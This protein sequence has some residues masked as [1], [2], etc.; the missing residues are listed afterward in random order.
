MTGLSDAQATR[1][2]AIA[3]GQEALAGGAV[4]LLGLAGLKAHYKDNW[5]SVREEVFR[6]AQI[7]VESALSGDDIVVRVGEHGFLLIFADADPARAEDKATAASD[8]AGTTRR[9]RP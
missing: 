8:A 7:A 5:E 6:H 2:K 1:L 9:C 4:R 3:A